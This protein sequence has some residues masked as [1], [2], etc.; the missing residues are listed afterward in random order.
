MVPS[1]TTFAPT[2][3]TPH[4]TLSLFDDSN[5]AHLDHTL[6][7]MHD[8]VTIANMGDYGINTHA[9]VLRLCNACLLPPS[10]CAGTTPTGAAVYN[11]HL[12][13]N[14]TSPMIGIISLAHRSSSVPPDMGW[15][16]LH[17]HSG[18]GYATEAGREV[19]RYFRDDFGIKEII[20]WPKP[21]NVPSVRTAEKIG[22]VEAG[23][24][25]LRETGEM[26]SVYAL[27]GMKRF[28]GSLEISI[29]GKVEEGEV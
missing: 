22:F 1:K 15:T 20:A 3:H 9:D 11:V 25:R 18:K 13:R 10:F 16:I 23:T 8:P 19:L 24:I 5:P 26:H 14:P 2:L 6:A 27:P 7:C 21:S 28:D 17:E 12:R 29:Y 4:L